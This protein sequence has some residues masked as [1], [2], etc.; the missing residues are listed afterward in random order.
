MGS[1][2]S[3]VETGQTWSAWKIRPGQHRRLPSATIPRGLSL[4]SCVYNGNPEL[5]SRINP[6]YPYPGSA[7][8]RCDKKEGQSHL[9][10][11][12]IRIRNSSCQMSGSQEGLNKQQWFWSDRHWNHHKHSETGTTSGREV[13]DKQTTNTWFSSEVTILYFMNNYDWL[14]WS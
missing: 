4:R 8:T 12:D 7:T 10:L 6:S 2:I 11:T 1:W 3:S 14:F 13:G 5:S 9:Y